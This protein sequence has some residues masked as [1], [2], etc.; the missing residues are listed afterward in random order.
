MKYFAHLAVVALTVGVSSLRAHPVVELD[1]ASAQKIIAACVAEATAKKQSHAI[2]VA[3]GSGSLIA[4]IRMD[5]NPPGVGEFAIQKAI[6]AAAWRFS[7]DQMSEAAKGTPGFASAP[8]VVTVPG[9]VPIYASQ[10]DFL[11]SVGVSGEAP[12]D[13]AACAMAGI[14]AAG[15]TSRR[16]Q[17]TEPLPARLDPGVRRNPAEG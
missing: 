12:K 10:G 16:H 6:A 3:D 11:G 13:D 17:V 4:F 7:T 8:N 14:E 1:A 9:G 15:F 2:A 5:G